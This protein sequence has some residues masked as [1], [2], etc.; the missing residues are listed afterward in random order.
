MV[1][2][3]RLSD[4]Y[5]W[6]FYLLSNTRGDIVAMND[7]AGPLTVNYN[8]D[9]WGKVLSVTNAAGTQ[10]TAGN[11]A[12]QIPVRYRG[13][14]YDEEIGLYYLQSRYYDPE[15]GRFLNADDAEYIGYSGG[16]LSYNAFAYCEN[17]PVNNSDP[18][19]NKTTKSTARI[20]KVYVYFY[21]NT[22]TDHIDFS[23]D[24][25]IY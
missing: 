6:Y 4:N 22:N 19:G 3:N 11:F 16:Q 18:S 17:E 5:K 9:V 15:M 8:Y 25:T 2:K 21:K 24:G 7:A 20:Y 23:I 14:Y 12:H 13:Y 1:I 10:H